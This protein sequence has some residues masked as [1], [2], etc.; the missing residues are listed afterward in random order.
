MSRIDLYVG[1]MM[2]GVDIDKKNEMLDDCIK[3]IDQIAPTKSQP[4]YYY[5]LACIAVRGRQ[6]SVMGRLKYGMMMRTIQSAALDSTR[7][8][9]GQ[10]VGGYEGGGILRVMGA[11][12]SNTKTKVL[13]L[14]DAQ[15]GLDYTRAALETAKQQVAPFGELSGRDYFE[16]GSFGLRHRA[17]LLP[18]PLSAG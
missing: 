10:L 12:R 11:V 9:Q 17:Q 7:N 4:Y 14:Y 3:N 2:A 5:Y 18:R 15:E 13:G 1:G 8:G 16:V 6:A